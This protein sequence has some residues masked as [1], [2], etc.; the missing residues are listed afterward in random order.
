[1]PLYGTLVLFKWIS[2]SRE[3]RFGFLRSMFFVACAILKIGHERIANRLKVCKMKWSKR[4]LLQLPFPV[5]CIL[6]M[7][8]I[9]CLNTISTDF[10]ELNVVW[11]EY[12]FGH[13]HSCMKITLNIHWHNYQGHKLNTC[14][15]PPCILVLTLLEEWFMK[16]YY[17]I[18]WLP[19]FFCHLL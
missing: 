6:T 14:L 10:D 8:N 7:T 16:S 19:C 1:M 12:V 3:V 9:Q 15:Q 4:K 11:A 2:T 5:H 13:M 18:S 17:A